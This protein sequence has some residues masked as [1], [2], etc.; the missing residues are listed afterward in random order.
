MTRARLPSTLLAAA[1][2][3]AGCGDPPGVEATA[4]VQQLA[5]PDGTRVQE[6]LREI[7]RQAGVDPS[8][9][10][11]ALIRELEGLRRASASLAARVRPDLSGV[12]SAARIDVAVDLTRLLRA[13]L[14]N[15]GFPVLHLKQ[16]GEWIDVHIATPVDPT[17]RPDVQRL[18]LAEL[19]RPGGY[20]LRAE[21]PPPFQP[22]PERPRSPWEGD[23]P[24][25]T[26]WRE[27]EQALWDAAAGDPARYVPSRPDLALVPTAGGHEAQGA[28]LVAL[29]VPPPEAPAL[30]DRDMLVSLRDDP[31]LGTPAIYLVPRPGR[32]ERVRAALGAEAGLTLWLVEGGKAV[33]AARLPG[34]PGVAVSFP[35]HG[36]DLNESRQ[37]AT[38]LATQLGS[39]RLTLPVKVEALEAPLDIDMG[40][41]LCE[42]LARVGPSAEP[43]LRALA[44][45]DPAFGALVERLV[46]EILRRRR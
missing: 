36:K 44:T 17:L 7:E 1:L 24:A 27:A 30:G 42:A 16:S 5:S 20:E 40:H 23:L 28:S 10:L 43:A 39:G 4:L 18:L 34:K 11:S 37:R 26:R 9:L 29:R 38:L 22:S 21:V 12:P 32:E 35:V 45:R 19:A 25:Y 46:E 14:I 3:L 31:V 6:A 15:A 8:P 2:G 33:L 13:R 41:P